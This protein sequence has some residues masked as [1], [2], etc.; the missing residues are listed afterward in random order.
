MWIKH[1]DWDDP[2]DTETA[3]IWSALKPDLRNV[4][5]SN[6]PRN[7]AIDG[8]CDVNYSLVCFCDASMSSYA[9]AIY[10][11]QTFNTQSRSDLVFSKTRVAPLKGMTIPRL[12]LM[13]VLIGV[14]CVDFVKH[15]LKLPIE[16][17]YLWSDSQCVLTWIS[18]DKTLSKFVQNRVDEIV[19]HK[20][21]TL[22]MYHQ[23]KTLLTLQV[24]GVCY[25]ILW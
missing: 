22:P 10:L 20:D 16:R 25:K 3:N 6:V 18:T 23:R 11:L 13:A 5:D 14:R 19:S 7:I 17:I 21:I 1:L 24:A 9:T 15:Q 12:E 8:E 2:L 4:S